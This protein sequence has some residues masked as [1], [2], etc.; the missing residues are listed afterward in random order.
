ME[1]LEKIIEIHDFCLNDRNL[2]LKFLQ[3]TE[4]IERAHFEKIEQDL[5][6]KLSNKSEGS[7]GE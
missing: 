4:L 3:S 7:L 1:H 2:V 5:Y 6:A